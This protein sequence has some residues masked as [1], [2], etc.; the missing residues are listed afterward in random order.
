MN[1]AWRES[2]GLLFPRPAAPRYHLLPRL[3]RRR[4]RLMTA[5]EIALAYQ[6]KLTAAYAWKQNAIK[7]F[8]K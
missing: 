1:K 8:G 7:E 5:K 6:V 3:E 2:T 4:I